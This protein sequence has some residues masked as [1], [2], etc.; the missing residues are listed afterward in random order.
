[1][2]QKDEQGNHLYS[3]YNIENE[4]GLSRP[5]IRKLAREIGFQPERNGVERRGEKCLCVN[6]GA[7]FYKP[8]SRVKRAKNQFCDEQCRLDWTKGV[9]H[10][11]F[12]EGK[13]MN[14][15]SK[16]IQNS[17]DYK[18]WK[19]QALKRAGYKC[20]I[21]GRTDNL[22]VHHIK[23]KADHHELALDPKNALVVCEE[24]HRRIH[25]LIREGKGF[26]EA[27]KLVKEEYS[28]E[29]V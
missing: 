20:E 5:Y 13:Y 19:E 16:W 21:T 4:T 23:N 11:S 7:F 15:F 17:S 3:Q 14:S 8:P 9:N 24:V 1:M 29:K 26:E 18:L 12:K 25:E 28:V 2:M 22:D 27:V 10:P 6:C